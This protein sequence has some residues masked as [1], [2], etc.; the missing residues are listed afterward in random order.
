M[1]AYYFAANPRHVDELAPPAGL[2]I[3]SF[4]EDQS[5]ELYLID[6]GGTPSLYKLAP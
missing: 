5:G 6:Y 1:W 4:A 3:S 2:S